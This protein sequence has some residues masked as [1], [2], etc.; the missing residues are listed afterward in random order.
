MLL[1]GASQTS[2]CCQPDFRGAPQSATEP[3]HARTASMVGADFSPSPGD[4]TPTRIV[5]IRWWSWWFSLG[6]KRSPGPGLRPTPL[7]SRGC[8]GPHAWPPISDLCG[9]HESRRPIWGLPMAIECVHGP[10]VRSRFPKTQ[11]CRPN[12]VYREKVNRVLAVA[13]LPT[14]RWVP[15]TT[16][17][18]QRCAY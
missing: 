8:S 18:A 16:P 10:K 1:V 14:P 17:G 15:W 5:H 3:S 12:R 4:R 9:R 6:P 7:V 11:K 13:A 2:N